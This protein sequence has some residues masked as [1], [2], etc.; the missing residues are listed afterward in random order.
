MNKKEMFNIVKN[1]DFDKD[2]KVFT[3]DNFVIFLLRPSKLSRK[4]KNYNVNK[5]FQIWLRE[6]ER[7][8]R[9]NHLRVLID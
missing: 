5:N 2:K 9:P 7:T 3:E 8:F 4:F 6:T 1:L